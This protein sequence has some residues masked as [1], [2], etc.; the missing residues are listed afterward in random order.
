[1][2]FTYVE[3]LIQSMAVRILPTVCKNNAACA[4]SIGAGGFA[5]AI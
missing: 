1:M 5:M 2:F 3:L 4:D